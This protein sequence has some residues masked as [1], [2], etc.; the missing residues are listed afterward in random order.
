M[1][2]AEA[3]ESR[4]EKIYKFINH[5]CIIEKNKSFLAFN[6]VVINQSILCDYWASTRWFLLCKVMRFH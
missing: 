6:I 4:S 1:K 3:K 5:F 2:L